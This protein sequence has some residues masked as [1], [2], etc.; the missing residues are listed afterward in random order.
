V[1]YVSQCLQLAILLEVSACPKPGNIHRAADFQNTRYEH[2]LASAAAITPHLR[3]AADRGLLTRE[4]KI[5]L[6]EIGIGKIIEGS[7][8]SVNKWQNGGNTIFGSIILLSPIAVAAGITLNEQDFS[9]RNLRENLREVIMSTTTLDAI[10]VYNA[11]EIAKPGGLGKA[12]NLDATDPKSKNVILKEKITLYDVF[13]I[14]VKYDSIA[15]EWVNNYPI[16]FDIGY[17]F[18]SKTIKETEDVNTSIVHTFL[19]I[20]SEVPDTLIARKISLSKAKEVSTRAMQI[21]ESGGLM[22]AKGKKN[23]EKFDIELR[24]P[25]HKLNPGTTADIVTA[26]LA[27]SILNGYRP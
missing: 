5:S 14:A 1:D 23:L 9:L 4:E 20:L 11:I 26:V 13:K 21:L 16:T 22:T 3:Q 8:R 7:V 18:F 25:G 6:R 19:R 2:F 27:I 12:P 17:P 24:D 10:N 15:A